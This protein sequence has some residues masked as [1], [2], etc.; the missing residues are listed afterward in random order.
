MLDSTAH[1]IAAL[2]KAV[3]L[4]LGSHPVCAIGAVPLDTLAAFD[5]P[6]HAALADALTR[7]RVAGIVRECIGAQALAV[8]ARGEIRLEG[9]E[10]W[11]ARKLG[12]GAA[13]HGPVVDR[14]NTIFRVA[15]LIAELIGAPRDDA[16]ALKAKTNEL[17]AGIATMLAT[18]GPGRAGRFSDHVDRAQADNR[19]AHQ[20]LN[21]VRRTLRLEEGVDVV[22]GARDLR[23]DLDAVRSRLV[24]DLAGADTAKTL[25]ARLARDANALDEV[26]AEMTTWKARCLAAEDKLAALAVTEEG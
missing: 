1:D 19:Y 11:L 12:G 20:L 24:L 10:A 9:V 18:G 17:A 15:D 22:K 21:E 4:L 8:G 25:R 14:G 23:A 5:I 2:A 3:R 16:E 13:S 26:R 6:D 7:L